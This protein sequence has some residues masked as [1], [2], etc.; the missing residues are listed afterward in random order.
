MDESKLLQE[1]KLATPAR[2]GVSRT[3]TRPL[4]R[5]MLELRL[6]HAMAVDSVYGEVS[7]STL[8]KMG[9]FSVDTCFGNK[10]QYL[11]RPDLGRRL[12]P[13]GARLLLERCRREPQ[14]Q[15]VVSDGLSAASIEANIRD[16]YPALLNSLRLQGFE[17]GTTFFVRGGRVG[18]M[19]PIGDILKPEC[20]ILLIGE[21]PGLVTAESMSAYMCYRPRTGRTDSD[22]LVISNIHRGGTSPMEAG[23]HI[24]TVVKT[25][26]ERKASG[27]VLN[28]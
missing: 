27:V 13:E 15:I 5:T 6:D 22:R 28:M 1:M 18:C 23:A 7:A 21:R 20:L 3:G 25:M 17:W 11:K 16:V 12:N 8:Q 4:T 19:D 2:I 26:L 14:V 9:F 10:E 24:G